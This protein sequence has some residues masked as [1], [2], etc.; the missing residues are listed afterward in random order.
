MDITE[1][2]NFAIKYADYNDL[3]DVVELLQNHP[4]YDEDWKDDEWEKILAI[5]DSYNLNL[6]NEDLNLLLQ[7]NKR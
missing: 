7:I 4:N 3:D 1:S 2:E 6:N 5:A